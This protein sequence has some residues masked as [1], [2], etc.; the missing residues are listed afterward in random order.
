MV[1]PDC[2]SK[3]PEVRRL[4]ME[5]FALLLA[6]CVS[7]PP[8]WI[9]TFPERLTCM[10][11]PKVRVAFLQMVRSAPEATGV[12]RVSPTV[13][14][15]AASPRVSEWKLTVGD[16]TLTLTAAPLKSM[17]TASAWVGAPVGLQLEA[18]YQLSPEPPTH[19]LAEGGVRVLPTVT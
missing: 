15:P 2:R 7:I 13:L 10:V 14:V 11:V 1:A 6:E 12:D 3:S 16:E 17:K 8:V 9:V 18:V 19:V 4:T 5:L